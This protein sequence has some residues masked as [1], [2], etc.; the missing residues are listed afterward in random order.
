M[1]LRLIKYKIKSTLYGILGKT[2]YSRIQLNNWLKKIE[3]KK[4][5]ILE[6]G[7]S[8]NPVIKKVKSWQVVEYKTLDNNLELYNP[9]F[10]L[11]LNQLYFSDKYGWDQ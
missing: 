3:V 1:N 11:D 2:S 6:V 10:D 9:D 7:A 8:L 4:D 5:R